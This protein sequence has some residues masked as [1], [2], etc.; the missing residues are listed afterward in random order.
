MN[1]EG[2]IFDLKPYFSQA[3]PYYLTAAN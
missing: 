1:T 3:F 2:R